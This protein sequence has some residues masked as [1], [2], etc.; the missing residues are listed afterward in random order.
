[1]VE[2]EG[3]REQRRTRLASITQTTNS[4]AVSG[5]W[6]IPVILEGGGAIIF[7][8]RGWFDDVFSYKKCWRANSFFFQNPPQN[9]QN[10][11]CTGSV[12]HILVIKKTKLASFFCVFSK[13][14]DR[15]L[16]EF[17]TNQPPWVKST[18][19]PTPRFLVLCK[20]SSRAPEVILGFPYDQKIDL[21]LGELGNWHDEGFDVCLFFRYVAVG[22][23]HGGYICQLQRTSGGCDHLLYH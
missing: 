18:R 9:P 5:W 11:N 20:T 22:C 23:F 6:T 19:Q 21:W 15:L 13:P 7:S 2:T 10:H 1:M 17:F 8:A 14:S 3:C 12:I 4:L 16:Y